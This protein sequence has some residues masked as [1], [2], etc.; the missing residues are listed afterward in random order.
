M[1]P[2]S[3][4]PT[5]I[6]ATY[7]S[8]EQKTRAMPT[9]LI[10][11]PKQNTVQKPDRSS[12]LMSLSVCFC[13]LPKQFSTTAESLWVIF[14]TVIIS[15]HYY[16]ILS[17]SNSSDFLVLKPNISKQTEFPDPG[18]WI[19]LP[20]FISSITSVDFQHILCYLSNLTQEFPQGSPEDKA[21]PQIC[22]MPWE[23]LKS[24]TNPGSSSRGW[25][26]H[27]LQGCS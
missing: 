15:Y 23:P 20:A 27:C 16:N 25:W 6:K 13:M 4:F 17:S 9:Q 1:C 24:V 18:D 8:E 19:L 11:T 22:W 14:I 26:G 3:Y 5:K 10:T 2:Q 7:T 21:Q 12:W